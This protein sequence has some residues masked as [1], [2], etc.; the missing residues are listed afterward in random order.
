MKTI[1]NNYIFL[2][3]FFFLFAFKST[4]A[5]EWETNNYLEK[6][7]QVEAIQQQPNN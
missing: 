1:I 2:S 3:Y 5:L 4:F 6:R 7:F